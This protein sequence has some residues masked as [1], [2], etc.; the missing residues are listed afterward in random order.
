MVGARYYRTPT[1]SV[2][3]AIALNVFLYQFVLFKRES[4]AEYDSIGVTCVIT[5]VLDQHLVIAVSPLLY[6]IRC[7]K[8]GRAIVHWLET[9]TWW[10]TAPR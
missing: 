2:K 9:I 6:L 4:T 5:K 8:L 7:T 3:S 10:V 1:G